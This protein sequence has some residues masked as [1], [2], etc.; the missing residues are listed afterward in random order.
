MVVPVRR[1]LP[2]VLAV[3]LLGGCVSTSGTTTQA[4][5]IVHGNKLTIDLRHR[6]TRAEVGLEAG[7]NFRA[8]ERSGDQLQ[9]T[10]KLPTGTVTI[11]AFIVQAATNAAGG[12]GDTVRT[13]EPKF[14]DIERLFPDAATA[15]QSLESDATALGLAEADVQRAFPDLG[16][17]TAVPQSRVLHGLV[18]D[19]LSVEVT[20]TDM[21]AG[22]V[23]ADYAFSIDVFHNPAVD[24]VVHNGVFAI[25]LTHRPTRAELGFLP[26]Y[27]EANVQPAWQQSLRAQ[28]TLPTGRV[29][30]P[31]TS[32]HSTSGVGSAADPNGV[33]APKATNVALAATSVADAHQR[34]L[35]D[36]AK[37]GLDRA[38]VEAVFRGPSG[39]RAHKTLHGAQTAVYDVLATVDAQLGQ[40]GAFA[41]SLAYTFTYR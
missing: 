37:L 31:V 32:V 28:L 4:G 33:D 35:S 8:Y 16:T 12:A 22:Q 7:R 17:G 38:A 30:L 13:H 27:W 1:L 25:D 2:A 29:E 34:L 14:F 15:R 5:S 36:A 26:T 23:Q 10:V 11:P 6:P 41:A 20:L 3:A 40:P 19:W 21:E 24:K 9:A 39:T 18:H